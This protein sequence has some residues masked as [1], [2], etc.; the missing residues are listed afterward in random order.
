MSDEQ[1]RPM[2]KTRPCRVKAHQGGKKRRTP[3]EWSEDHRVLAELEARIAHIQRLLL[4][5]QAE[6]DARKAIHQADGRV[7]PGRPQ[8]EPG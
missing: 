4:R 7:I 8:G 6:A 1:E 2:A 3:Q 5:K